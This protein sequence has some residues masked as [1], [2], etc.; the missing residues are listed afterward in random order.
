MC[1]C[2]T[3]E[4]L[5]SE[6]RSDRWVAVVAGDVDHPRLHV[7]RAIGRDPLYH[8]LVVHAEEDHAAFGVRE[9]DHLAGHVFGVRRTNAAVAKHDLLEL[10]PRILEDFELPLNFVECFEHVRCVPSVPVALSS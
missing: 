9:R 1:A 5:P 4:A 2:G 7:A 6:D 8:A 10:G 3:R